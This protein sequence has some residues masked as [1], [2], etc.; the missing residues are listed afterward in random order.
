[1]HKLFIMLC[2]V[3]TGQSIRHKTIT[4]K[5]LGDSTWIKWK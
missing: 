1:M 3:Y 5:H 4:K 2:I